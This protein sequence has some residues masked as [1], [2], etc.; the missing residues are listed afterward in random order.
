MIFRLVNNFIHF[1]YIVYYHN[2]FFI[3]LDKLVTWQRYSVIRINV[4]L[5]FYFIGSFKEF[6]NTK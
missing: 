6:I 1:H 3:F 4:N 5:L 2:L